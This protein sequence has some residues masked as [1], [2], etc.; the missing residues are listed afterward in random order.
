MIVKLITYGETTVAPSCFWNSSSFY[1]CSPAVVGAP[2]G[3]TAGAPT[4]AEFSLL[5]FELKVF[6]TF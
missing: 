2:A 4:T 1:L 6:F 3:Q 5:L